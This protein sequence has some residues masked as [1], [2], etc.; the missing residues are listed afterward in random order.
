[1]RAGT[2]FLAG[3]AL[4]T[5]GAWIV[6]TRVGVVSPG[7]P[8]TPPA[9]APTTSTTPTP[10]AVAATAGPGAA[11]PGPSTSPL[12]P[13]G[14]PEA[15][16]SP[17]ASAAAATPW[18]AGAPDALL[19]TR[20]PPP[21]LGDSTDAHLT[22]RA[23]APPADVPSLPSVGDLDRLRSR[24]L[25]VPVQGFDLRHLRDDFAEKRGARVH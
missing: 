2:A 23:L 19:G 21:A 11:F 24:Q 14:L 22:P 12:A 9:A 18:E 10:P 16:G 17:P 1:M 25:L 13:L 15:P 20:T 6:I 7:P 5:A 3:L 8:P 4:G